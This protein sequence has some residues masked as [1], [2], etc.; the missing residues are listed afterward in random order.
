MPIEIPYNNK[1]TAFG[2][3]CNPELVVEVSTTIYGYQPFLFLLDSGADCTMV[4]RSMASLVGVTLPKVPDIYVGG[5][6]GP[7]LAAFRGS[8]NCRIGNEQFELRCLFTKSD[9][10][11]FLLGRIDFFNLFNVT[12]D[13][14]NQQIILDR[15]P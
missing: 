8:L 13:N 4:P 5:I 12:F 1:R 10:T 6:S 2:V 14:K 11:P 9:K 7:K 3:V 15:L